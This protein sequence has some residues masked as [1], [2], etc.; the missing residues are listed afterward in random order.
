[1]PQDWEGRLKVEPQPV[2]APLLPPIPDTTLIDLTFKEPRHI[3]I[4]LWSEPKIGGAFASLEFGGLKWL[5]EWQVYRG[6]MTPGGRRIRLRLKNIQRHAT[7]TYY[8]TAQAWPVNGPVLL[9]F[10]VLESE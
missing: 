9:P 5:T 8:I 4:L 1:M 6:L 10:K 2:G 7:E 3:A